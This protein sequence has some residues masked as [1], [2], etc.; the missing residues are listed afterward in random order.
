MN[1]RSQPAVEVFEFSTSLLGES[2]SDATDVDASVLA[3]YPH[4]RADQSSIR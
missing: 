2:H 1:S 3:N 4:S